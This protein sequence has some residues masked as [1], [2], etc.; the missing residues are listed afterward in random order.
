MDSLIFAIGGNA[1]GWAAMFMKEFWERDAKLLDQSFKDYHV[2]ARDTA[3]KRLFEFLDEL[4]N[5]V[6]SFEEL[7]QKNP[8][9]KKLVQATFSDPDFYMLQINAMI[10]STRTSSKEKHKLLARIISEQF[11]IDKES[12]K[13][14]AVDAAVRALPHLSAV[15]LRCLG[16]LAM[17]YGERPDLSGN[18]IVPDQFHDWWSHVLEEMFSPLLPLGKTGEM[19]YTHLVSLACSTYEFVGYRNLER[20]LSPPNNPKF[21]WEATRFLTES[22]VGKELTE[23]WKAGMQRAYPTSVGRLIGLHFRDLLLEAK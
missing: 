3:K 18:D 20:V 5:R 14:I 8:E 4:R 13:A 7:M 23:A 2:K 17:T 6:N 9:V 11:V 1:S 16:A 10:A 15:Q 22:P 12:W 21:K 19:D